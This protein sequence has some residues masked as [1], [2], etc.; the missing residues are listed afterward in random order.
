MTD[1]YRPNQ[2]MLNPADERNS[3]K[4]SDEMSKPTPKFLLPESEVPGSDVL[5]FSS[6]PEFVEH[7]RSI[8]LSIGFVPVAA[9]TLGAAFAILRLMLVELVIVDG[10]TGALETQSILKRARDDRP[11]VPVLVVDQNPDVELGRQALEL[12]AADY[13]GRPAFQDDVVRALLS[14]CTPDGS[15]LWGPQ[16]N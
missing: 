2:M 12:G 10:E 13:L 9:N 6:S 7:H 4:R 11:N 8:L 15:H 5:I 14:H 16:Q 1:Q 3:C